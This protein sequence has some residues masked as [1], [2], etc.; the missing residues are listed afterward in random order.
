MHRIPHKFSNSAAE[1]V[2][3][4][5][6]VAGGDNGALGMPPQVPCRKQLRGDQALAMPWRHGHQQPPNFAPLD[7]FKHVH[8]Q[9]MMRRQFKS[10][11]LRHGVAR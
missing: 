2:G 4:F 6:S 10:R 9:A 1:A 5:L 11:P 7:S 8:Q 3:E